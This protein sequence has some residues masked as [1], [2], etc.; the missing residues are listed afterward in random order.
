MDEDLEKQDYMKVARRDTVD[1]EKDIVVCGDTSHGERRTT[2][3]CES[4][5]SK[6]VCEAPTTGPSTSLRVT[7]NLRG[8]ENLKGYSKTKKRLRFGR[9][10]VFG[11]LDERV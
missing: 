2:L 9:R 1:F 10:F 4:K 6:V 3:Q 5:K 8:F 11:G 7:L